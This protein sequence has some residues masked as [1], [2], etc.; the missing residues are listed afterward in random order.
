MKTWGIAVE[1]ATAALKVVGSAFQARSR[2]ATGTT[3]RDV[4]YSARFLQPLRQEFN[5]RFLYYSSGLYRT[6]IVLHDSCFRRTLIDEIGSLAG[7]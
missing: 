5:S 6:A 2:V 7:C 1:V 4:W 3:S